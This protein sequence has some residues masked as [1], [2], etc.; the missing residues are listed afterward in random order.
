MHS[1]L[2]SWHIMCSSAT[3]LQHKHKQAKPIRPL[4]LDLPFSVIIHSCQC[5]LPALITCSVISVARNE[6]LTP[7]FEIISPSSIS[8]LPARGNINSTSTLN[9]L[10]RSSHILPNERQLRLCLLNLKLPLKASG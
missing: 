1:E 8:P 4:V 10:M 2:K 5:H 7:Y 9:I 6:S 3:Y